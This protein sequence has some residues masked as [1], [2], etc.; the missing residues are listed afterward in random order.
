MTEELVS[1]LWATLGVKA[2]LLI[3]VSVAWGVICNVGEGCSTDAIVVPAI[4]VAW[5]M[6]LVAT[7]ALAL[8]SIW[9]PFKKARY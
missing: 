8:L 7:V 3:I 2:I 5:V 6:T 1:K 9:Y 4:Q